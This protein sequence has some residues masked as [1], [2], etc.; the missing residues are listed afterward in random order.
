[1]KKLPLVL[2][3]GAASICTMA[4]AQSTV[5]LYGRLYPYV[6]YEKASGET[7]V[8]TTVST[9]AATPAGPS[10]IAGGVKGMAAGNSNLGF[11]GKEDLGGGL[12]AEFQV[13]GTVAVDDGNAAGFSWN[14]NTFVG[15][16]GGFGEIRLGLMDTVFKEYGDTIGVL[17]VSSGTPASS[18]NILRKVGFGTSNN[19]RFHE[20]RP[21]SIRYDSP[22]LFA[23]LSGALQLATNEGPVA[24]VTTGTGSAKTYSVGLK[25]DKGP[26]YLA[27]AH[28]I[29][30][31][32]YGGSSS[33]PT[34][35]R[36][37]TQAGVSSKDKATQFTAEWRIAKEHRFE[38][39]YIKKRYNES[40]NVAGRFESYTNNAYLVAWEARWGGLWRTVVQYTR[41]DAGTCTRVA[42]VCSTEGLEGSKALL[43]AAYNLSRRT[44]L[45]AIVDK[46]TNGK[47]ARFSANDFGAVNPGESTRHFL[48]GISHAF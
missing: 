16:E 20:R 3:L 19:G 12:K 35:Q 37:L 11:R 30:D 44:Y 47:S 9:L 2:A 15:L 42:A 41:S 46:M 48:A 29:H 5:T 45:Y 27:L 38:F 6:N 31:N 18:S 28:E 8:G 13:E 34:A 21:N 14:R 26:L 4:S 33:A 40:A 1:M 22:E 32:Y 43:G 10:T 24:G 17:G 36:N 23:G 39:D 25:Y 7:A